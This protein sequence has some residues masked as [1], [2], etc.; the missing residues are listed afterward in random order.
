MI[1]EPFATVPTLGVLGLTMKLFIS[2]PRH[3]PG[4]VSGA[5]A[6]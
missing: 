3:R 6:L 1:F 5:R 2:G 4:G